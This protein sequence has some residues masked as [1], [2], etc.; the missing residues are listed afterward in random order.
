MSRK[1]KYTKELKIKA[2]ELYLSSGISYADVAKQLG[3]MRRNSKDMIRYWVRM[4][5]TYG[6]KVFDDKPHNKSYSKEF[7]EMVVKEYLEG[8]GSL[9]DLMDKYEIYSPA[10]V[11]RWINDYN[12]DIELKDYSPMSE[13]YMKDTRKT[14]FDERIEIVK[15]C[16]EHDRNFK[17]AALN[18]DCSYAQVRS[19][20][21]KYE[22]N[23]EEA[24]LDKRGHRKEEKELSDIE[25]AERKIAELEKENER[26]KI[27][28]ELLKKAETL[29]RR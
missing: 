24:L 23:G 28:Y 25:K 15:W 9:L 22:E 26:L 19:W 8:K 14:T 7:K 13:V 1:V 27:K 20:V 5:K 11:L 16:I 2:C 21:I 3:I 29:E 17:E 6:A 18:F 4:Y 12:N 10:T